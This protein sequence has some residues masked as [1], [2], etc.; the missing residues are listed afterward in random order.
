MKAEPRRTAS[1][2]L[3]FPHSKSVTYRMIKVGIAKDLLQITDT[4]DIY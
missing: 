3:K 4:N 2:G 1:N